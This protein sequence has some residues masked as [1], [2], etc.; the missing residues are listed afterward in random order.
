MPAKT[1][2]TDKKTLGM[3]EVESVK[4]QDDIKRVERL[5]AKHH[6]QLFADVWVIG[7]N[8]ALRISDLI[9]IK[10]IDVAGADTLTV[11][12]GKTKKPRT[13]RINERARAV[14]ARRVAENPDH[15]YLFQSESNRA[16]SL[17]KPV[18]RQSVARAFKDVGE[19]IGVHL[20]THS[21]RKTR[22]FA[23]FN[24]GV[25]IEKIA[26][27]FNHASARTTR[28]YVGIEKHEIAKTYDDFV[29]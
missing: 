16:R 15:I 25:P 19:M 22:G 13:I 7:I 5:L 24:A 27:I 11:L 14:I 12:E 29:L 9:E 3:L 28:R 21:M 26:E 6:G 23:M 1:A 17:A 20:G 2:K 4:D 10:M 8:F 18:T